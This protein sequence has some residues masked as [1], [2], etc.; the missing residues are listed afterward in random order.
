MGLDITT[1]WTIRRIGEAFLPEHLQA[2]HRYSRKSLMVW[3]AIAHNKKWNLVRLSIPPSE[4]ADKG[5][6]MSGKRYVDMVLKGPLKRAARSMHVQTWG[7]VLVVEDGAPCHTC[8]LAK[9][10][11]IKLG[12]KSL[13]HPPYSSD[14]NPIEN[15]WG[16]LKTKVSLLPTWASSLDMLWEQIQ[17]CW[18]DI[19]QAYINKLIEGMPGRVED[20]R[21]AGGNAIRF[22]NLEVVALM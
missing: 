2:T 22:W 3:G 4:V 18:K 13:V 15:V 12:I 10:A 6:G 7:E 5:K 17:A 19:D 8:K 20:V 1:F 14:L 11:R 16:M 9:D 21:K